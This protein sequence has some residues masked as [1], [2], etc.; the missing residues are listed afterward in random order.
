MTTISLRPAITIRPAIQQVCSVCRIPS[1]SPVHRH[2]DMHSTAPYRGKYTDCPCCGKRV[3]DPRDRNY[4]ARARRW[5]R[6]KK[7]REC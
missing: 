1:E 3:E 7:G 2:T 6:K 4:Q 5:K